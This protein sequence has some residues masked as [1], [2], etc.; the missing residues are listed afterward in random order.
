MSVDPKAVA[1]TWLTHLGVERGVSP[2]TLSNYRR[3]L[4]RYLRYL[5]AVGI[6]DLEKVRATDL[7]NYVAYLRTGD[8]DT[9]R[10]PLAASSSGR[11]LVVARGLHKFA[12]REGL[13]EIDAAS[14]VS[15]PATAQHLPDT[16][17]VGEVDRLLES[18]PDGDSASVMDLR[19]KAL[20][21]VLYGTGARITEVLDL[22]VDDLYDIINSS[23]NDDLA[24]LRLTGKGN[25]QRLV[26][27]GTKAIAAIKSYVVRA[28]PA[29]AKGKSAALFLNNR[30][31]ALS[32]QSAWK[33]IKQAAERAGIE[34][35]ISPHTLRHS[36]ATHL[37]EGG[38]DVRVVQELLGHASVKTTQIYTHVTA[39]NLRQVWATSHPR[40]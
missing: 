18:I 16:L 24:M 15:P 9:G 38:A 12:V 30:G 3:D 13:L 4:D 32:R 10:A 20:L 25:K 5:D 26:P 17:S 11:A 8:G 1:R 27:V 34:K 39:D 29:F 21:E 22:M 19:E 37:L 23:H 33:I 31:G 7:E 40:A 6:D 28:R 35:G 36:Y 14:E 2:N